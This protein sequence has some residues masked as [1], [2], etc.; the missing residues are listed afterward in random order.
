MASTDEVPN[1]F[2]AAPWMHFAE[3][4]IGQNERANRREVD[5]YFTDSGNDWL[6]KT[7]DMEAWC[8]AFAYCVLASADMERPEG[9]AAVRAKEYGAAIA[10]KITTPRYGDLVLLNYG[11]TGPVDH[12]S[13]YVGPD[14]NKPGRF[15]ALGGNQSDS[16]KRSSFL[17]ADAE[18]YRPRKRK[19]TV[20]EITPRPEPRPPVVAEPPAAA[21]TKPVSIGQAIAAFFA[22]IGRLFRRER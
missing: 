13:F 20:N 22:A 8:A 19:G 18:F 17:L 14:P 15:L 1:A 7:P 9:I 3:T 2:H 5:Q 4:R 21:G 16:V 11:R 6:A 10:E 12:V